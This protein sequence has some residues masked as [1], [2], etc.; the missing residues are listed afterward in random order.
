MASIV[1]KT[2]NQLARKPRK[3]FLID[4]LGAI[5]NAFFLFVVLRNFD[6]YF[7]MPKNV[8]THLSI[9]GTLFFIYSTTCFFFLKKHWAP[10]IIGISIANLLYSIL[11]MG[12]LIIYSPMLTIIGLIY[13]LMEIAIICGLVYIELNVATAIKQNRIDNNR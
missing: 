2:I 12:L 4:S 7:G 9:T 13:F 1:R 8:L 6:E 10:F 3:L 5:F 11:T